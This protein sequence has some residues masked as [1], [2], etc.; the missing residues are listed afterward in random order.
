MINNEK[1]YMC[2]P[3]DETKIK[4]IEIT[5]NNTIENISKTYL[6]PTDYFRDAMYHFG[7]EIICFSNKNKYNNKK[8]SAEIFYDNRKCNIEW[9]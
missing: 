1:C 9:G 2:Y 3:T 7:A 5:K 6:H 4:C 8:I